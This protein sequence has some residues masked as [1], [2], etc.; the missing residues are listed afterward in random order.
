VITA[1]RVEAEMGRR[2]DR[3]SARGGVRDPESL[4]ILLAWLVGFELRIAE[5]SKRRRGFRLAPGFPNMGS[6]KHRSQRVFAALK[7][8][9]KLIITYPCFNL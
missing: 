4:R 1:H 9:W 2:N 7:R 3:I 6:G 5:F 8:I